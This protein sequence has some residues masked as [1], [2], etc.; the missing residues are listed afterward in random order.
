M[1]A[2]SYIEANLKEL[3][4][5]FRNAR[6]Q[7][8]PLYFSKLAVL[9]LC[10]WVEISIDDLICRAVRRKVKDAR[11][12]ETFSTKLVRNNYGFHY[13]RNF[14]KLLCSA[15]GEIHVADIE[16]NMDQLKRQQLES[17]LNTLSSN[18]NSLAHTYLKGVTQQVDAPSRTLSRFHLTYAGLKEF[19]KEVFQ[20]IGS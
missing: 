15:I 14:R 9:E 17:E 6:T 19:E 7:K 3:D 13:E 1:I 18:R 2:K 12:F 4:R 16:L 20:R 10:G 11:K 8:E 5:R